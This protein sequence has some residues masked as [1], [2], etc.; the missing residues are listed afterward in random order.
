MKLQLICPRCEI[1]HMKDVRN[2][3]SCSTCEIKI[4]HRG[5]MSELMDAIAFSKNMHDAECPLNGK[6]MIDHS[7]TLIHTC[8]CGYYEEI[9]EVVPE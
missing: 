2:I 6:F 9:S 4:F 1:S 8:I 3:V 7:T 5:S